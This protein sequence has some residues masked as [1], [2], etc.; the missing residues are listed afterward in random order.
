MWTRRHSKYAGW[1]LAAVPLVVFVHWYGLMIS[2][3][4]GQTFDPFTRRTRIVEISEPSQP[5][6]LNRSLLLTEILPEDLPDNQGIYFFETNTGRPSLTSVDECAFESAARLNPQAKIFVL[7]DKR[8]H[9]IAAAPDLINR[10]SNL[11]VHKLNLTRLLE[12]SPLSEHIR[13]VFWYMGSSM[14]HMSDLMKALM[15]Y[16]KGG[17]ISDSDVLCAAEYPTFP[18]GEEFEVEENLC[19]MDFKSTVNPVFLKFR[20]GH[21]FLAMVLEDMKH[22]MR[23]TDFSSV[24][25]MLLTRLMEDQCKVINIEAHRRHPDVDFD[26]SRPLSSNPL[27]NYTFVCPQR[28]NMKV[29]SIFEKA[30]VPF[31][32]WIKELQIPPKGKADYPNLL[33]LHI[34]DLPNK[35]YSTNQQIVETPG[36]MEIFKEFCPITAEKILHDIKTQDSTP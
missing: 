30:V 33:A 34:Q 19:S 27:V 2:S 7:V 31:M 21:P 28:W 5:E 6:R 35:L 36:T 1:A 8:N 3:N 26:L 18:R 13:D 23:N 20:K 17:I 29:Y 32:E 16:L 14:L 10:F 22:S 12:G 4:E 9:H 15:L 24:G 11:N 25:S